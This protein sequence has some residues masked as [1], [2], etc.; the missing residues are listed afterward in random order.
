LDSVR[1]LCASCGRS[2]RYPLSG[3]MKKRGRDTKVI[4]WLDALTGDCPKKSAV[5]GRCRP[6]RT[7]IAWM[8]PSTFLMS[9]LGQKRTCAPQPATSAMGH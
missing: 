8:D 6:D 4:D 7:G 9:A 1:I 5:A 3:L 2:G